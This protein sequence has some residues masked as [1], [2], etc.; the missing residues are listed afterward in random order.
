MPETLVR[1]WCGPPLVTCSSPDLAKPFAKCPICRLST[2]WFRNHGR[3]RPRTLGGLVPAALLLYFCGADSEA[4]DCARDAGRCVW[5]VGVGSR[6]YV[7]TPASTGAKLPP[8][9][10]LPRNRPVSLPNSPF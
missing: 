4:P 8:C 3:A 6:V 2:A 10:V 1:R 7:S 9:G 5:L